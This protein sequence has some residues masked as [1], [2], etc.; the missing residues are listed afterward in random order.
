VLLFNLGVGTSRGWW[1]DK[2]TAHH[3]QPNRLGV[4]PDIEGGPIAV[5]ATQTAGVR[6]LTLAI[7]RRQGKAIGPLLSLVG[8]QIHAYSVGFLRNR[9]LR[10]T[11]LE[12]GLLLVHFTVYIGGL[13]VLLGPLRGLIFALVHQMLLGAYMGGAFL[14]NHTGM[15]V[16]APGDEVDFLRRQVLTA[17]NIRSGRIA[18]YAFGPLSCQIEH[19]LF[20]TMPRYAL[21]HAAPIVREFCRERGIAYHET[22]ALQAFAEVYRHLDGIGSRCL[23][24]LRAAAAA[25]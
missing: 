11:G 5:D 16:L 3:G 17:R 15:R 22:G 9:S 24:R 4:D 21:R 13:V 6:G 12:A 19:H 10:N 14:T 20:P 8:I 23:P 25:R 2:H 1:V 7:M 18:D